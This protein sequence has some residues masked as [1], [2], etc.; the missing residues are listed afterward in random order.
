MR[1]YL[2][3]IIIS[4]SATFNSKGQDCNKAAPKDFEDGLFKKGQYISYDSTYFKSYSKELKLL[5]T[6]LLNR[7]L[8]DYCF[9]STIFLSNYYEYSNVET[10]LAFSNRDNNNSLL[11]HS[12]VF[13]IE[14][15]RFMNLFYGLQLTDTT[16]DVLLAKEITS[17][18][19]D[20]TYKGHFNRLINLK[21][22]SVISFE[23]WHSDLSWRIYDYYFD[24]T[25]KLI[26]IKV[27]VGVKRQEMWEGYKRQ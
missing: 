1:P 24:S 9:Y 5:N 17:I 11:I 12:P 21:E 8:P 10:V 23:L 18:F 22:K 26:Q 7:L 6:P 25:N 14:S 4:L 27:I 15:Q 2:L 3:I 20:I 16:Q 19:S 13:T